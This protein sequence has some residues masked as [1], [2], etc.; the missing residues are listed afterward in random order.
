MQKLTFFDVLAKEAQSF[1][2]INQSIGAAIDERKTLSE[3][4]IIPLYSCIRTMPDEVLAMAIPLMSK[5]Q[6][7]GLLDI[8][9]WFKDDIDVTNFNRWINVYANCGSD[10]HIKEFVLGPE[11]ALFFKSRFGIHTFDAEEPE[12]PDH[13]NYF[14]TDDNLLL[15]E[16]DEHYAYGDELKSLIRHLYFELGVEQAY[17]LLFK[18]VSDSFMVWQEEE[19]RFKKLRMADYGVVDYFDAL[20][21]TSALHNIDQLKVY[22]K[23]KQKAVPQIDILS[24]MQSLDKYAIKAYE[25]DIDNLKEEL[26]L[27]EDEKILAFL[28]FNFLRLANST[29]E[30][31]NA[32]KMGPIALSAVGQKT[33]AILNLGYSYIKAEVCPDKER[34]LFEKYDFIDLYKAG[35]TLIKHVQRKQKKALT[36]A[37][38]IGEKEEAFL[39]A[40]LNDFIDSSFDNPVKLFSGRYEKSVEITNYILWKKWEIKTNLLIALIPYILE[41]KKTFDELIADGK[42]MD[43][44]YYNYTLEEVD[45]EALIISAFANFILNE[46]AHRAGSKLGLTVD[47]FKKFISLIHDKKNNLI[48]DEKVITSLNSFFKTYGLD[49]IQDVLSYMQNILKEQLD[50]YDYE[51]MLFGDFKHVGGPLLFNF[52][53][54]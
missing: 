29:I 31:D 5:E 2:L 46:N 23:K 15:I 33:A 6:R 28:R 1:D 52:V 20:E 54:Q 36:Q 26:S 19:L 17:A 51:E 13:D 18:I 47:E 39:G 3:F 45:F 4:P 27:I 48:F 12:Y 41:F 44:F 24:Q 30:M 14:L 22:L 25:K 7:Q 40:H 49:H 21:I 43:S 9:L 10:R 8:D 53:K 38:L 37:K 34:S 35:S 50:G 16:Y 42:M 11:F 32:L